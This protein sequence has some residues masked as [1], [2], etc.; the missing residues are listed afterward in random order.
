MGKEIIGSLATGGEDGRLGHEGGERELVPRL[1]ESLAGKK[2]V[3]ASAGAITQQH[4]LRKGSSSPLGM[5]A[6]GGSAAEGN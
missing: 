6:T 4:G 3:G 5:E 2:V 1:V